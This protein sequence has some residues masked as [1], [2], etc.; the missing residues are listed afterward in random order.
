MAMTYPELRLGFVGRMCLLCH[1]IVL[2]A[3][4]RDSIEESEMQAHWVGVLVRF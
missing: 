4:A 2:I 1:A 3:L